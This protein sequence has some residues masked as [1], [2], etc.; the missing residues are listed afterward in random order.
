M[1]V[2]EIVECFSRSHGGFGNDL[3]VF[4]CGKKLIT[5]GYILLSFVRCVMK[6]TINDMLIRVLNLFI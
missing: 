3:R 4:S 5:E 1:L 2:Q 6:S